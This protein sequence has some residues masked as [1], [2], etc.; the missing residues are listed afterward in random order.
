L[1]SPASDDIIEEL[2]TRSILHDEIQLPRSLDDLIQLHY[3]L[4]PNEFQDVN[5]PSHSLDICDIDDPLLLKHLHSH[6]LASENVRP[7]LNLSE[8]ALTDGLS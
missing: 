1:Y 5:L 2:T 3:M 8:G 6:L 7:K 4:V